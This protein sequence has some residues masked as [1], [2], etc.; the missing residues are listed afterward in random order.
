MWTT[1]E[2]YRRDCAVYVLLILVGVVVVF[3][4]AWT[5][6][7]LWVIFGCVPWL[8][9]MFVAARGLLRCD[10][11]GTAIAWWW[12]TSSG[13]RHPLHEILRAPA[14]PVCRHDAGAGAGKKAGR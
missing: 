10:G 13:P 12:M 4:T 11:C 6:D 5:R 9:V 8:V 3:L 2:K 1:P 14:C 7:V